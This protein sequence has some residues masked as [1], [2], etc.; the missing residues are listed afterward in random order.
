MNYL[1]PSEYQSH[2][3]DQAT[4]T[5]WITAASTLIDAHCRRPTLSVQQYTERVRLSRGR[6]V[7]RLTYLPLSDTKANGAPV[8]PGEVPPSPIV[9]LRARYGAARC[10]E[11]VPGSAPFAENAD[12]VAQVSQTFGLPGTWV[13]LDPNSVDYDLNTG[14][15]T[16]GANP[17]GLQFN[18]IEV[19]YRAGVAAIPEAIKAACAQVVRNGQATPALNVKAGTLDRMHLEYFADTLVD[20]TVRTLLAPY[21]AQKVA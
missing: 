10:G 21:V 12:L 15:I 11:L 19:T 1:L 2:G 3:L 7:A 20:D 5:G 16:I 4:P 17:L 9:S 18:E 14:E 13:T 6:N 8:L